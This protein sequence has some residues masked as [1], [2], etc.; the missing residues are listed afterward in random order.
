MHVFFGLCHLKDNLTRSVTETY[1]HFS[2]TREIPHSSL[3]EGLWELKLLGSVCEAS[4]IWRPWCPSLEFLSR[5][6]SLWQGEFGAGKWRMCTVVTVARGY[7]VIGARGVFP[8]P[9]QKHHSM[10]PFSPSRSWIALEPWCHNLALGNAVPQQTLTYFLMEEGE[11]GLEIFP[12]RQSYGGVYC[13]MEGS[14]A[15]HRLL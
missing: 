10:L 11:A 13:A 15:S 9:L 5:W 14:A 1:S 4:L 3:E 2:L 12:H 6:G 8:L 7:K